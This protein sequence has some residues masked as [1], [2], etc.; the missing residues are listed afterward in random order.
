[1]PPG[2]WSPG[3]GVWRT[4]ATELAVAAVMSAVWG[5][6]ARAGNAGAGRSNVPLRAVAVV[7]YMLEVAG[8]QSAVVVWCQEV[9][10]GP[11]ALV[12]RGGELTAA[13]MLAE[14]ASLVAVG[15]GPCARF[16]CPCNKHS[17]CKI[18]S[19]RLGSPGFQSALS[20]QYS[21]RLLAGCLFWSAVRIPV[22]KG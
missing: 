13:K 20:G 3:Q 19:E 8:I 6:E 9:A 4:A 7:V 22:L 12:V 17:S 2:I 10:R 11:L 16:S 14:K 1:V 18:A 21:G 15:N 5:C